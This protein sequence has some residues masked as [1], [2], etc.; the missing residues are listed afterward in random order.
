ML[1]CSLFIS[2]WVYS[3]LILFLLNAGF[4]ID[5][6]V[7]VFEKTMRVN[8]LGTVTSIKAVLPDMLSRRKGSIVVVS[9]AAIYCC[10]CG[11]M[12]V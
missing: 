3:S 4:L 9:S 5:Q 7:G 8:Y 6:D 12:W 10:M 11:C 2:H 1:Y